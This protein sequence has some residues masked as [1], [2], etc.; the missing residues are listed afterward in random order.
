MVNQMIRPK[1]IDITLI[2]NDDRTWTF[3]VE[4]WNTETDVYEATNITGGSFAF[5][6][7]TNNDVE[8]FNIEGDI[9]DAANGIVD[10]T[11]T[12]VMVTSS[13]VALDN[14]YT[15]KYTTSAG[16]KYTIAKGLVKIYEY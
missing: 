5:V 11:F 3:T 9:T 4:K 2:V 7:V 6:A 16:N 10:V 8:I 15:F 1:K 12:D 14:T 13:L